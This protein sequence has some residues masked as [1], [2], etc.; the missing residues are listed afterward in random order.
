MPGA[1]VTPLCHFQ[2]PVPKAQAGVKGGSRADIFVILLITC[3]NGQG[4]YRSLSGLASGAEQLI[5]PR[6]WEMPDSSNSPW[7]WLISLF[8]K[9]VLWC[10][11][12]TPA[13]LSATSQ[14]LG[15]LFASSPAFSLTLARLPSFL[16][17]VCSSGHP[18]PPL[19]APLANERS[20]TLQW[21]MSSRLWDL[22]V[23]P[24]PVPLP[25]CP[26]RSMHYFIC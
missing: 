20:K 8:I 11:L 22:S 21:L 10:L 7:S 3:V 15:H 1:N 13:Y 23:N 19:C 4:A 2:H 24:P 9:N 25:Y 26:P 6:G 17:S 12:W 16:G 18:P 14:S 5:P